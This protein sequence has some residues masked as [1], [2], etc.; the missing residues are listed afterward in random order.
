MLLSVLSVMPFQSKILAII[1]GF[2]ALVFTL[3]PC[4]KLYCL[5]SLVDGQVNMVCKL[6]QLYDSNIGS[7]QLNPVDDIIFSATPMVTYFQDNGLLSI[8]TSLGLE[9]GRFYEDRRL[10]YENLQFL[11]DLYYNLASHFFLF[12]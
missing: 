1:K 5:F 11:L 6:G 7:A 10:N 2:S 9:V 12:Q 8:D 4:S 3:L